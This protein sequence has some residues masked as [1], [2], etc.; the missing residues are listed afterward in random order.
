M[1][2][3]GIPQYHVYKMTP[4]SKIDEWKDAQSFQNETK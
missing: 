3:K 4:Q 2:K 1:N